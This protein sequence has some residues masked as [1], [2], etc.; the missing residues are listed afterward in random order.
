MGTAIFIAIMI[1]A[2]S[3]DGFD[4]MERRAIAKAANAYYIQQK[5]DKKVKRLEKEYIP[6]PVRTIGGYAAWIAG[7]IRYKGLR[8]S[9]SF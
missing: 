4:A 2:M 3:N 9:W 1:P 6:K 5:L 8:Y 7:S